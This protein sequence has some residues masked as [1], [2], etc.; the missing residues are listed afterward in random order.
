MAFNGWRVIDGDGH[1][2]ED[3]AEIADFLEAP[4]TGR[5]STFGL[6]RLETRRDPLS[7]LGEKV[8]DRSSPHESE[9]AWPGGS[10]QPA[11][12]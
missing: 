6:F 1:V 9:V 7:R 11:A 8:I 5:K 4:Y 3:V 10:A 2:N 12:S